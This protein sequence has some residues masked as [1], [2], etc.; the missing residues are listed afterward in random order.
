MW[1]LPNGLEVCCWGPLALLEESM[2]IGRILESESLLLRQY[3]GV[4]VLRILLAL[5]FRASAL[6][7]LLEG[8][9]N[10]LLDSGEFFIKHRIYFVFSGPQLAFSDTLRLYGI[11]IIHAVCFRI[12]SQHRLALPLA[13]VSSLDR[14]KSFLSRIQIF[15]LMLHVSNLLAHLFV[16]GFHQFLKFANLWSYSHVGRIWIIL[17][18]FYINGSL[19]V[20][21]FHFLETMIEFN[22]F[23]TLGLHFLGLPKILLLVKLQ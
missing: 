18:G 23:G 5:F 19:K 3:I 2:A 13:A 10:H 11:G 22:S 7:L 15:D 6:L 21:A 16:S 4:A 17:F 9:V 1:V 14:S 8:S 20:H 12:V